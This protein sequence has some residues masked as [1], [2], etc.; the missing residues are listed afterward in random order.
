MTSILKRFIKN[1]QVK[2]ILLPLIIVLPLFCGCTGNEKQNKDF[3]TSGDQEADERADQRMAQAEQLKGE[4]EGAGDV[5]KLS[6]SKKSLYDRLGGQQELQAIADDFVTRAMA[7]PR[8]NF[9]RKGVVQGGL[10]IHRD[11]SVQ[12][13]ATPEN[14]K[15]LKLHL[16]Q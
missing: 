4:G 5:S 9:E 13:N 8:V 2:T 11:R 3:Y 15:A 10:S 6:G 12:W 1:S 16:A 14:I 7:D